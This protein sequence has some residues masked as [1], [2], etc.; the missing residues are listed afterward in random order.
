MSRNQG[1]HFLP[2]FLP[3]GFRVFHL[4]AFLMS[5]SLSISNLS[6]IQT[7]SSNLSLHISYLLLNDLSGQ[8]IQFSNSNSKRRQS[9]DSSSLHQSGGC[10]SSNVDQPV[11]LL[12]CMPVPGVARSWAIQGQQEPWVSEVIIFSCLLYLCIPLLQEIQAL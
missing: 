11:G 8:L 9:V 4:W 10:K 12:E 1:S 7:V 6:L 2:F 5:A 3:R